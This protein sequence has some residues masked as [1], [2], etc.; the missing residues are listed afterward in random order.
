MFDLKM[1]FSQPWLLLLLIPAIALGLL[2]YLRTAKR[3]RRNR[4]RVCSLV[5]HLVVMTLS[6]L[7]LSGINFTYREYNDNNEILFVVDAS[8]STDEQEQAKTDYI[9]DV[10]NMSNS[11]AYKMGI[12]TF[13]YDQ[14]YVA[15]L[16]DDYGDLLYRYETAEKPNTDATDIAAALLFA[17]DKFT[18]PEAAKIVLI[19]DGVETDE[20][21]SAVIRSLAAD[22]IR[23]DAVCCS[24]LV[25]QSEVQIIGTKYPD[26]NI[27]VGEPFDIEL[28]VKSTAS[29]LN[30]VKATL[31][32]SEGDKTLFTSEEELTA[33]TQTIT[34]RHV[35]ENTGLHPFRFEIKG[36]GDGIA[37]NNAVYSYLYLETFDKV[38]IIGS[39]EDEAQQLKILLEDYHVDFIDAA[40][41][42]LPATLEALRAYDEVILNNIANADLTEAFV[43][44]LHSYVYEIGGGLFTVGGGEDGNPELAHAYNRK[45]LA[46]TKLQQMLPVQAIDYTPP[47]GLAIIIDV[48]GSMSGSRLEAAKNTATTIVQ[49]PTC[50]TERDYCA[51]LT[52][53]DTYTEEIRPIPMTRQPEILDAIYNLKTGGGTLFSPSIERA[54]MDLIATKNDGLIEK[55]HVMLVTDGAVANDDAQRYMDLV[56]KYH[57]EGISFSFIAIDA[58]EVSMNQLREAAELGGGRAINS[59]ASNLTIQV[60]DDIRVPEIKEVEYGPFTPT[61]DPKSYY[62]MLLGEDDVVPTLEGFYGTRVRS[63]AELSIVGNYNV[64]IFA[65]WKYGKGTVGSFMCDLNGVWSADFLSSDVGRRLVLGMIGKIFPTENIQPK[66]IDVVLNEQNYT[67]QINLYPSTKL[68]EGESIRVTVENLADESYTPIVNQPLESESYS[69]SS[70]TATAA[71]VYRITAERVDASGNPITNKTVVFKNFSYSAE[72]NLATDPLMGAEYMEQLAVYGN[73]EFALITDAEPWRVLENFETSFA[74]SYDPRLP[75]IIIAIVLFLLDIAV[76]KF[77]FKWIHELIRERKQKKAEKG[78]QS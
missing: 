49:D 58:T 1:N 59:S 75:L 27:G 53:S 55:M 36:E 68:K 11:N 8:F 65:Q 19:S 40:N 6:I 51:I 32:M 43:D 35:M 42:E 25:P 70:F 29:S 7:V 66:D 73:G 52:L 30:H 61:I 28:T 10:V 9:N 60:K 16:T 45:D 4:N 22:G 54:A 41:D 76:R 23:V 21:A 67:T 34:V 3:Y 44:V 78:A 77:K 18:N 69:R 15:P 39:S 31:T 64:P 13:G 62:A 24:T 57:A 33:A 14:K 12:V 37:E 72:Y 2:P 50:L 47:L 63:T 26:V 38:L 71:G 56:T 74:R 5:L 17:R 46:G 20:R 48:S